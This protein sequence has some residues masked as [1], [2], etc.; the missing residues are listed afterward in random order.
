MAPMNP[1]TIKPMNHIT[2]LRSPSL[3]ERL[4]EI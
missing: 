3:Y 1:P 4:D 2:H